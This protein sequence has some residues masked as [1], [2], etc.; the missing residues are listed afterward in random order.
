MRQKIAARRAGNKMPAMS[1]A[2]ASLRTAVRMRQTAT[3]EMLTEII[4][5]IRACFRIA[6]KPP[7]LVGCKTVIGKALFKSFLE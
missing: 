7:I 3:K 5:Q 2:N 4:G 1:I 6:L